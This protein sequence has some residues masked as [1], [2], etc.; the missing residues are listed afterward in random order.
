MCEETLLR[1]H[2]KCWFILLDIY[3]SWVTELNWL[4]FQ[5]IQTSFDN[6]MIDLLIFGIQLIL[7]LFNFLRNNN[8]LFI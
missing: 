8:D 2:N 7:I 6:Q 5:S 4:K 1:K 3:F